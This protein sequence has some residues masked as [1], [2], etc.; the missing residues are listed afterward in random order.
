MWHPCLHRGGKSATMPYRSF[1]VCFAGRPHSC[2]LKASVICYPEV[3]KP[4]TKSCPPDFTCSTYKFDKPLSSQ[5]PHDIPKPWPTRVQPFFPAWRLRPCEPLPFPRGLCGRGCCT[6]TLGPLRV[7][8]AQ[9][10]S[11]VLTH[12]FQAQTRLHKPSPIISWQEG[13]QILP[14]PLQILPQKVKPS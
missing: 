2:T 1:S 5:G 14:E 8:T 9:Q 7:V 3:R 13:G 6:V 10:I 11:V 4:N 12:V